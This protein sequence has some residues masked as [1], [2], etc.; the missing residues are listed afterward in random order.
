[1]LQ[2]AAGIRVPI[3]EARHVPHGR[4]GGWVEPSIILAFAAS[5]MHFDFRDARANFV[6]V[7]FFSFFFFSFFNLAPSTGR[8]SARF[9]NMTIS[10]PDDALD[11]SAPRA[12]YLSSSSIR[13]LPSTE[14]EYTRGL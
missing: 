14:K 7:Y 6:P 3:A 13:S 2:T 12:D 10:L 5:R 9:R 11:A 1:M 4:D 8:F